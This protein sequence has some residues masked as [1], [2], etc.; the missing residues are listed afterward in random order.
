MLILCH[1]GSSMATVINFRLTCRPW[2]WLVSCHPRNLQACGG[3]GFW[4]WPIILVWA[5]VAAGAAGSKPG[6]LPS[7]CSSHRGPVSAMDPDPAVAV[8]LVTLDLVAQWAGL[9]GPPNDATTTRGSLFRHLGFLGTEHP[10]HMGIQTA[11][12]YQAMLAGWRITPAA[13]TTEPNPAPVAPTFSQLGQAG[14]FGRTCRVLSGTE[15]ST[16]VAPPPVPPAPS[17]SATRKIKMA[18]V[19][20]QTDDD[21]VEPLTN[22]EIHQAYVMYQTKTGGFPPEDEE[23]TAE[24]ITTL[25]NLFK[26]G[27]TPYT[28]MA[29]WGPYQLRL[30]KKVK[31][32]GVKLNS[33]G[34]ITTVE[35]Y[36]PGEY[37]TWRACYLIFRTGCIMLDQITASCLDGYEKKIRRYHE[38]YGKVCWPLIYQAD[39]RARL[40]QAERLK[41]RG[42]DLYDAAIRA[43]GTHSFDPTKPWEWVWRT[44]VLDSE[45]W[46]REVEEPCL[47]LLARSSSLSNLLGEDA[48]TETRNTYSVRRPPGASSTSTSAREEAPPPPPA[49]KRQRG[50]D[51]R[52]HRVGEDGTYTHNRRGV[53]L[54]RGFQSGECTETDRRGFCA[55][56]NHRRRQC[57]KCLSENHGANRCPSD[58]PRPPRPNHQKGRGKKGRR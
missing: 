49:A 54:C 15:A 5:C 30:Q 22:A 56:Y 46:H 14:L 24:Q 38:R 39:V 41:R 50:P 4:L 3:L 23:L 51:Q 40:E 42:Q 29:V 19:I 44:L 17:T 9:E 1:F 57:A 34:E 27:R 2:S 31:M 28:D 36:G 32:R 53:E 55:K 43:G 48:P 18:Q 21:E 12:D 25:H 11:A 45:F 26:M 8:T 52:E 58:G 10:R 37:E 13:T 16:V 33:N 20:N 6:A 7:L 35:M 47:L